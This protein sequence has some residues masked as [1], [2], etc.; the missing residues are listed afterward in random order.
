MVL[1]EGAMGFSH[2]PGGSN[3]LFVDRDAEF[4]RFPG[5]FAIC[6]CFVMR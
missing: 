6:K 5:E 1:A 4:I 3:V 2:T